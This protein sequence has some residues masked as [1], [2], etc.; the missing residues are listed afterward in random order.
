MTVFLRA[1]KAA[2][3]AGAST[4]AMAMAQSAAP[5]MVAPIEQSVDSNG[6]D[7]V[8][9]KLRIPFA[10]LSI[11]DPGDGGIA[12]R[13]SIDTPNSLEGNIVSD[14]TTYTVT[15]GG[16][17]ERFTR[18]GS[19]LIPEVKSGS[20]LTFEN[21]SWVYQTASGAKATFSPQYGK[22]YNQTTTGGLNPQPQ[23]ANTNFAGI[24]SYVSPDGHRLDYNYTTITH[25]APSQYA[26]YFMFR[27]I[28]SITSSSG[29][30][31]Q[32]TYQSDTTANLFYNTSDMYAWSNRTRVS[33]MN[34]R[35]DSCP[36]NTYSCTVANRPY[37]ILGGQVNSDFNQALPTS[38]TDG[39]GKV[40]TVS[41]SASNV[42]IQPPGGVSALSYTLDGNGR[43]S[44]AVVGG[45]TT[46]YG[47]PSDPTH[48]VVTRT[49]PAGTETWRYGP[50]DLLLRKRIDMSGAVTEY[51]YNGSLQLT[52][53]IMPEGNRI[54]YQRDDRGNATTTTMVPKSG[55]LETALV[56]RAG[57][58]A[59]CTATTANICN[60]PNWT[61]D[62]R[63][64]ADPNDANYRTN[65]SY[66]AA[67]GQVTTVLQPA[68]TSGGARP[69]TSFSYTSIGGV[70]RLTG[71]TSCLTATDCPGSAN[72]RRVT[73]SYGT[74]Q[75]NNAALQSVTIA[76]GDNTLSATTTY[77][78]TAL[79][80]VDTVDGPLAGS[81][82]SV[83]TLYDLTL[84]RVKGRVAP[85]PDGSG[86]AKPMATRY[87]Y[88]NV[89]RL[90]RTETGVVDG[91][92][93]SQW[94]TFQPSAAQASTFD[95]YGRVVQSRVS[96]GGTTAGL[97][98]TS[99]DSAG[100]VDCVAVR[101]NAATL[102]DGYS[103]ACTAKTAGA[104]GADRI[105]RNAYFVADRRI[106]VTSGY[107]TPEALTQTAHY[108]TNGQQD[109]VR[110][111]E[112]NRTSYSYD[113]HDRL[114]RTSYPAVTPGQNSSSGSDFEELGYDATSNIVSKRLRDGRTLILTV[115]AL[116]RVTNKAVPDGCAPIQIGAC[117]PAS[118][119]RDV[120]YAYDL[121][122]R[123]TSAMFAGT[124]EGVSATYD[125][126][127]R[128]KSATTTMGGASRTL[129]YQYDIAG[130]RTRV[131]HPDGVAF[132]YE[133]D[134][135][136]RMKEVRNGA[137]SSLTSL[138]YYN[139]GERSWLGYGSNGISTGYD[140]LGRLTGYNLQRNQSGTIVADNTTL[141]Y[142]PASQIKRQV[143]GNDAYSWTGAFNIDR[144]YTANGLN[145]YTA[146]GPASLQYDA[147]GNLVTSGSTSYLYDAEN[148]LIGNSQ[149]VNLIYDPLGR[150][151]Q[152]STNGSGI[153]RFLY[154]G[155]AL[156][157]EY[158]VNGA[159]LKRYVH[160]DSVDTPV[161]AYDG[162]GTT[163]RQLMAD[164]QGSIVAA[165]QHGGNLISINS[166]D[167]FGIPA[168]SNTGRFQYTGQAWLPELGMYYY[169]ARMYSP[170]LGRFMQTD[171]IGYA[172]GLNWYNYVGS[173]PINNSDPSGLTTICPP[174]GFPRSPSYGIGDSAKDDIVVTGRCTPMPAPNPGYTEVP[175]PPTQPG[176]T[177]A[178]PGQG[179][180][181]NPP[182]CPINNSRLAKAYS[183]AKDRA[184]ERLMENDQNGEEGY[185]IFEDNK[186]GQLR[187]Y[188]QTGS[189]R[190]VSLTL[191]RDGQ[192]L[193]LTGH[194]HNREVGPQGFLGLGGWAQ[195][196]PSPG[197]RSAKPHFPNAKF[198]LHQKI[199]GNWQDSCY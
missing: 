72:E 90:Q 56:S 89:G 118:A 51:V 172:D 17:A 22:L 83:R 88:D 31:L 57:Y 48:K 136:S 179:T 192:T 145:Q 13:M 7:L 59:S 47:Y 147:N 104:D 124:S 29:Y 107:G 142:N 119:T 189:D 183:K 82:D 93:D 54:D 33:L 77:T 149:G 186:T 141:E 169:K 19:V 66:D 152:T 86:S 190:F 27:R 111:G 116:N 61:K 171:P 55:S 168:Q 91:S 180:P 9:G 148:R 39:E 140:Q 123:L 154:D 103:S 14:G 68:P 87:V 35:T 128:M 101:M 165:T 38:V 181:S 23:A 41:A 194:I 15:I 63:G 79:G 34:T 160:G 132:A 175:S 130:K 157:A 11:G 178:N 73:M 98:E 173:D 67:T 49:T 50:T 193:L 102:N 174:N 133:Y 43:V 176:Q 126:L 45:V 191:I 159:L 46:S 42:T 71:V 74:P 187:T 134:P 115:D 167:E 4:S 99:Y 170:T 185:S 155:D 114:K 125:A 2:C 129:D 117:A 52:S 143:R 138:T 197:D 26:P 76:S 166:Y 58:D 30:Q 150:L 70:S 3:I 105:T 28:Q 100:R 146:A 161:L 80:D 25:R 151:F 10:A 139:T 199:N 182:P 196:G 158:D 122:G 12:L 95:S 127:G 110:D 137:G 78:Y 108:T 62:P 24:I 20:T 60:L 96:G 164:H 106:E 84:R 94:S 6:V 144:G 163:P 135:L 16:D 109:W 64:N 5:P 177:Q 184:F 120:A 37:V 112:A 81:G 153:A 121:A 40:T 131:T 18:S 8:S 75:V 195:R 162:T 92:A 1:M 85:D 44:Q 65:Y 156:V 36:A 97:T 69:K 113:G 198:V 21:G 53:V 32:Y 188:F